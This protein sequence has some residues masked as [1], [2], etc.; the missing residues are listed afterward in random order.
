MGRSVPHGTMDVGDLRDRRQWVYYWYK[1]GNLHTAEY[2]LSS[3]RMFI[4]GLSGHG[5]Q[6][7]S[8][9]RL[10]TPEARGESQEAIRVRVEEFTGFLL[11]ELDKALP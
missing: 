8:L 6:G 3:L 11:P 10:L 1:M 2:L 7:T 4:A 5:S 9:V